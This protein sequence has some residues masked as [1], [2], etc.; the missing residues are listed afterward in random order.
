MYDLITLPQAKGFL[1]VGSS[2]EECEAHNRRR[3]ATVTALRL[4][5]EGVHSSGVTP[6]DM[7]RAALWTGVKPPASQETRQLI[8]TLLKHLEATPVPMAQVAVQAPQAV[9]PVGFARRVVA[10][11]R[12]RS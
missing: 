1:P 11:L 12:G 9:V 7:A 5:M 3:K 10:A 8:V 4:F 6:D 2:R